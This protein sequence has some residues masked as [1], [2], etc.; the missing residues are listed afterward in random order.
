M[1][2]GKYVMQNRREFD[3]EIKQKLIKKF[4]Y[5]EFK[6]QWQKQNE[7]DE[8]GLVEILG[9]DLATTKYH[10]MKLDSQ[11]FLTVIDRSQRSGGYTSPN[12]ILI[13]KDEE[14]DDTPEKLMVNT[15][16]L[17][18]LREKTE[19]QNEVLKKEVARLTKEL[20][21]SETSNTRLQNTILELRNQI[22]ERR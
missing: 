14:N 7:R 13:N 16:K 6:V 4:G 2:G 10:I 22:L 21:I 9:L 17:I 15:K 19:R 12:I 8:D 5:D 3:E 1:K 18:I 11:G 20:T